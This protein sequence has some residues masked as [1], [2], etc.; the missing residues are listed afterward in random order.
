M[1]REP[2]SC[3]SHDDCPTIDVFGGRAFGSPSDTARELHAVLEACLPSD[4]YIVR[5]GP[6]SESV[7]RCIE[8]T[9]L[10]EP[11]DAEGRPVRAPVVKPEFADKKCVATGL[12]VPKSL[13][14]ATGKLTVSFR[15][16]ARGVPYAFEFE[17]TR[18]QELMNALA[19]AV[20]GCALIP[21]RRGEV[22][23]DIRMTLP[24]LFARE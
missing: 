17:G 23:L 14:G 19:E 10:L 18:R 16:S 5:G 6:R 2:I 4:E 15:V 7:S 24:I 21:A 12:R 20:S 13:A 11:K 8:G 9:C 22:P 3:R 1:Q